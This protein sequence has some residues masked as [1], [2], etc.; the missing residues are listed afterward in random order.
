MSN[1]AA[2]EI[3]FRMS[4]E[5][6]DIRWRIAIKEVVIVWRAKTD[7]GE[8]SDPAGACSWATAFAAPD[9]SGPCHLEGAAAG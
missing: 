4:F 1:A 2:L 8:G 9:V 6:G 5:P 7:A 3:V